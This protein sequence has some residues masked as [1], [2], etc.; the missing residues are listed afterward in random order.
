VNI[1]LFG[2][3]GAGKGT[4]A[5][6]LV[7]EFDL[8]KVSTGDLL[9][10]EI[11]QKTSLGIKIKSIIAKGS[12]VSDNIIDNL[13]EKII[14]NKIYENRLIFDGCPR[15]LNQAK[16]LDS[17]IN[18]YDQKISCVL[19]L[20]VDSSV[21]VKRILGRQVCS[22]CELIFNDFFNPATKKNHK[23]DSKFLQKRS[24]DNAN[25]I[26]NRLET[27]LATTKPILNYYEKQKLLTNID[28]M[29]KIDVIYKEIRHIIHLLKT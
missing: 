28:G 15:N 25:V 14:S 11:D 18:K 26:K 17:L 10:K 7:N 3:P 16:N 24:D 4:Q 27:Y 6:N 13:I 19:N 21:I 1:I 23:C 12:L 2:P 5:N 8:F 20:K 29:S 22:K 9:R